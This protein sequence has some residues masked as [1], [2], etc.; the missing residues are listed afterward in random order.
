MALTASTL[1]RRI[2]TEGTAALVFGGSAIALLSNGKFL[3]TSGGLPSGALARY[4]SNGSLDT[5]FGTS[6]QEAALAAP[7]IAVQS[8]GR[9]VTAGS[10]VTQT[11][12][13]SNSSG[14]GLIHSV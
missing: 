13:T 3:V 14:F 11:S 8:N 7:G 2:A 9:I 5:T 10:I 6:G 1:A 12:L 4:N